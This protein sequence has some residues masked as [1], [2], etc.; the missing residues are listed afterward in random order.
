MRATHWP[1]HPNFKA[2]AEGKRSQRQTVAR[3]MDFLDDLGK[4]DVELKKRRGKKLIVVD[5]KAATR[6]AAHHDRCDGENSP[7]HPERV[8][9]TG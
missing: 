6:Y 1:S 4:D 5:P 8:I 3:V 9:S 7:T 2:A